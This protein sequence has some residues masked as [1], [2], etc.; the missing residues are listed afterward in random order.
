MATIIIHSLKPHGC[1]D[2]MR[3]R[4]KA[5]TS[6]ATVI[7][8]R[9]LILY[10]AF[11]VPIVAVVHTTVEAH[12]IGQTINFWMTLR[13]HREQRAQQHYRETNKTTKLIYWSLKPDTVLQCKWK[14]NTDTGE[15]VGYSVAA[16]Q[17]ISDND[18]VA[19]TCRSF[20]SFCFI[21]LNMRNLP[22]RWF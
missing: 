3:Q 1:R 19:K 22:C 9:K 15:K 12:S 8:Q 5:G 13:A 16:D 7:A 14:E 18:R 4:Q 20:R 21:G 6:F 2:G 17:F 10:R 11:W